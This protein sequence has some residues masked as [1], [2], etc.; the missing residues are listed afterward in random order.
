MNN[1]P[2]L[3]QATRDLLVDRGLQQ[4]FDMLS[5]AQPGELGPAMSC[6]VDPQVK[7]PLAGVSKQEFEVLRRVHTKVQ[8]HRHAKA[9]G[10]PY[11]R[12]RVTPIEKF[13]FRRSLKRR[14]S[15]TERAA[16]RKLIAALEE[17]YKDWAKP[18]EDELNAM[19]AEARKV[20]EA[21]SRELQEDVWLQK[22][23]LELDI[24]MDVDVEAF[25]EE[26]EPSVQAPLPPLTVDFLDVGMGD[27]TLFVCGDG[28]TVLIDC[29][30]T[31]NIKTGA[32][33]ALTFLSSR[34]QELQALRGLPAPR[35]DRVYLTHPD[36]DHY[37]LLPSLFQMTP[38]LKVNEFHIGGQKSEYDKKGED[39]FKFK[40]RATMSELFKKCKVFEYG[41]EFAGE[42]SASLVSETSATGG[43][44]S[45]RILCANSVAGHQHKSKKESGP[46]LSSLVVLVEMKPQHA[47]PRTP[48]AKILMM[49]DGEASV[50]DR[51]LQ[52]HS[53]AI[54]D[55]TLLH[56]GH[57]GSQI[58]ANAHFLS[59]V[60]P[61]VA[62]VS[63]DQNWAHP[64]RS[65]VE[66][67]TQAPGLRV[68]EAM[69]GD[70]AHPIVYGEG[71][72][73]TKVHTQT[74][75]TSAL[76]MNI[77]EQ[78]VDTSDSEKAVAARK[79]KGMTPTVAIGEQWRVQ[80]NADGTFE[81]FSTRRDP[82]VTYL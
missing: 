54:H 77:S 7:D 58:A 80:F 10:H 35:L 59:H 12:L 62:Q 34:L 1:Q 40:N 28:T 30:T 4:M 14:M 63:A 25:D 50:E 44:V 74:S 69:S 51:L 18:D 36:R 39:V 60:N 56:I 37:N 64:Y 61:R 42:K 66:R 23:D 20:I 6:L 72:N 45:F 38:G 32:Q 2:P 17:K 13:V 79:T 70:E 57:H 15:E 26:E 31:S 53:K 49:G 29:G 55:C 67:V 81:A 19:D 21:A 75:T 68:N 24:G 33:D 65:T 8:E 11:R 47:D 9:H 82:D 43:P 76:I 41:K 22:G 3:D 5:R 52:L 46:N 71:A 48:P 73:A 16:E 78:Q 27:S